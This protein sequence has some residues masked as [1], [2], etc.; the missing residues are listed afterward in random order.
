MAVA[1]PIILQAGI[2][3]NGAEVNGEAAI[4]IPEGNLEIDAKGKVKAKKP[5]LKKSTMKKG[6]GLFGLSAGVG[7]LYVPFYMRSVT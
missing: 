3:L 5:K 7:Y 4:E 1:T 6:G 2:D